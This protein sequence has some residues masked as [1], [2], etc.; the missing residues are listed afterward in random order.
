MQG[1]HVLSCHMV[2]Y[3][4]SL[5]ILHTSN[6]YQTYF[7]LRILAAHE[8][9]KRRQTD[10]KKKK[11]LQSCLPV[12]TACIWEQLSEHAT[13]MM[14]GGYANAISLDLHST[15]VN[16]CTD[17]RQTESRPPSLA[18]GKTGGHFVWS[19]AH[20]EGNNHTALLWRR[21]Q[22]GSCGCTLLLLAGFQ[23]QAYTVHSNAQTELYAMQNV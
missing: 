4:T 19:C 11:S 22:F 5:S 20:L 17:G 12:T 1:N 14:V 2:Q 18:E 7:G 16:G 3:R 21:Q 8:K 9:N 15:T 23:G 6:T 13:D 10:L